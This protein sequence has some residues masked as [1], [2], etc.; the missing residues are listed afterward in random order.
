MK[1]KTEKLTRSLE[2]ANE[3]NAKLDQ[4]NREISEKLMQVEESLILINDE[5]TGNDVKL[6]TFYLKLAIVKVI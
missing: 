6:C 5:L 3:D 2:V 4:E 1:E